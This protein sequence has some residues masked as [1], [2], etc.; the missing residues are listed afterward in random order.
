MVPHP[1]SANSQYASRNS[2]DYDDYGFGSSDTS[3]S[4]YN[5]K[6][7]R[8]INHQVPNRASSVTAAA[9]TTTFQYFAYSL[10]VSGLQLSALPFSS[11][12]HV[13]EDQ[14]YQENDAFQPPSR[15]FPPSLRNETSYGDDFFGAYQ[16][17]SNYDDTTSTNNISHTYTEDIYDESV[18]PKETSRFIPKTNIETKYT[19][20]KPNLKSNFSARS[21]ANDIKQPQS[22]SKIAATNKPATIRPP[23]QVS[24]PSL[25][26]NDG[27]K[28]LDLHAPIDVDLSTYD[29]IFND[30][31]KDNTSQDTER[32]TPENSVEI[33]KDPNGSIEGT[34]KRPVERESLIPATHFHVGQVLNDLPGYDPALD[35]FLSKAAYGVGTTTSVDVLQEELAAI[36]EAIYEQN[37]SQKFN[38]NSPKQVSVALYG[39][40]SGTKSYSTN[41]DVLEGMAGAGNRLAALILEYRSIKYKIAKFL[42]QEENRNKGTSVR[43]AMTVARPTE[44]SVTAM[45]SAV[46]TVASNVLTQPKP[47]VSEIR[48]V[49]ADPLLL[50]D[51]SAYIF[52]AYYS[53]P[54]IHRP[55]GM[56]TGAVMGFCKMLN[57]LL[58]NRM[59]EG[60]QPR[61]VLCFDAKGKTFR[62]EVYN[63]YKANRAAAP[64][65]LVP[66]F[67]LVR[68]AAK[69][70]GICQIEAQ[71]FEADDVIATLAC[72][73]IEEGVDAN[74][75]SGDKDLM[76]LVTDLD[77][78]PS[79]QIIDPMKK[80][81][82]TYQQ[83]IEK[84]QVPPNKL[85]DLL[86]L[87][88]DTADNVPG[89]RGIGPK[90]AAKLINDFGSLE[91]LLNNI[92]SVKQQGIREKLLEDKA[93]ARLSRILVEL[94]CTVPMS[95]LTGLP[96]GVNQKVSDLRME[97]IDPDRIIAFYD[98][99]GFK[100]LKRSFQNSLKGLK[101]KRKKAS[102]YTKRVK[103]TIPTP[104]DYKDVPF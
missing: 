34:T 88:G 46:Q 55:D 42:R 103:A 19:S 96:D 31:S 70:Y 82:T 52:R 91:N 26:S 60:E 24:I 40:N 61:L 5:S 1:R 84:W 9:P 100:E 37:N 49:M 10:T 98:Q 104:E 15:P 18:P 90:T 8:Y 77:A 45:Q 78:T 85:G 80:E 48:S 71:R 16:Y 51:A 76:Q 12:D 32:I 11:N 36:E 67:D 62:H 21:S 93:N 17:S 35:Q 66:Q 50:L 99:M 63:K 20:S 65:D 13:E 89:V 54:P 53:M 97:A 86:A 68:Q 72:K 43:S 74:I 58:L 14:G 22:Y 95:E 69:A 23:V 28:K 25:T 79:I 83:V 39:A 29:N 6:S 64:M 38:I 41:K 27:A 57:S 2:N 7:G 4:Y 94:N 44:A 73:A 56:P 30:D 47:A 59:L 102:S 87:A 81:R 33:N 3:S 75:M 92:D 101:V